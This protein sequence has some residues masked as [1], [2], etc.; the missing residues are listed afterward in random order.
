[1]MINMVGAGIEPA[2]PQG[3]R[4]F[5]HEHG[6]NPFSRCSVNKGNVRICQDNMNIAVLRELAGVECWEPSIILKGRIAVIG[7]WAGNPLRP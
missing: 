3:P 6:L 1:M 4:N 5:S 2:Q 7:I